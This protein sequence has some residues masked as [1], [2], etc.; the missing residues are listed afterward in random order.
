M[1]WIKRYF[2]K[3]DNYLFEGIRLALLN[4]ILLLMGGGVALVVF[5]LVGV[6]RRFGIPIPLP[7]WLVILFLVVPYYIISF[8]YGKNFGSYIEKKRL[9][10]GCAVG[11]IGQIPNLVLL[12]IMIQGQYYQY[13]EP[14]V[15][16]TFF[17]IIVMVSIVAPI[18]TGLGSIDQK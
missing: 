9:I 5:W 1:D 16:K 17:T 10:T 15:W 13:L 11:F 14:E 4:F 3:T 2:P 6:I 7:V 8:Q 18:M 12:Y